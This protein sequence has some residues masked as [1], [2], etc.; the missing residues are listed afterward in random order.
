MKRP[1]E[2]PGSAGRA[3]PPRA[4]ASGVFLDSRTGLKV[5]GEGPGGSRAGDEDA[6]WRPQRLDGGA[7]PSRSDWRL[8]PAPHAQPPG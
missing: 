8:S 3:C 5:P 1:G 2:A 4:T 7:A 6:E